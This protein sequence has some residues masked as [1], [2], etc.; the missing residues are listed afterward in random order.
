MTVTV[1]YKCEQTPDSRFRAKG[2]L[3]KCPGRESNPDL[4]FRR[5]P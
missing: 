1:A 3:A 5:P 2:G 4:R